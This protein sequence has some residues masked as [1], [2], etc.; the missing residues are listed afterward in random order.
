V[1]S[2]GKFFGS[3]WFQLCFCFCIFDLQPQLRLLRV[4]ASSQGS[5]RKWWQTGKVE[6]TQLYRIRKK[7]KPKLDYK[8]RVQSQND[9]RPVPT[10][11]VNDQ[12]LYT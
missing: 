4:G 7:T 8:Q 11:Y 10:K 5:L 6:K 9:A 1:K 3:A 12:W 2:C